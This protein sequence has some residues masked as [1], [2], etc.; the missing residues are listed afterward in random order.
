MNAYKLTLLNEETLTIYLNEGPCEISIDGIKKYT[1]SEE[2]G[3]VSV[4]VHFPVTN[5]FTQSASDLGIRTIQKMPEDEYE[6]FENKFAFARCCSIGPKEWCVRNGC[7][8]VPCGRIC[9]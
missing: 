5:E 9:G 2:D 4:T 1:V 8:T 3:M 6:T 7:I